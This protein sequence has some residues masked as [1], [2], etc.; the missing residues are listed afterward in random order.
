MK[1]IKL[2][3]VKK[4][5]S[6]PPHQI[7]V[8]KNITQTF[9]QGSS[10]AITGAS[11]SGKSTLLHIIGGLDQPTAGSIHYNDKPIGELY[12][13]ADVA[14][15]LGFVFQLPY[16]IDE[17]TVR[18][19]VLLPSLVA[20]SQPHSQ[21]EALAL[22]RDVGLSEKIDA[23][24]RTLSGGQQQRVAIARALLGKPAFL[25]A[26]EPTGN[27]DATTGSEIIDLLLEYQ[28]KFNMGLIICS[29]DPMIINRLDHV[30][31]LRDGQLIE[32][33]I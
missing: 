23:L 12:D 10:Y 31:S 4:S 18:E 22:L 27:L 7:E 21:D 26:D 33:S 15:H 20:T 28:K 25:L 30:V 6:V 11:G 13:Q 24:P 19:N 5:F 32:G 9:E 2:Q 8:L 3:S 17:L 16:L 1:R 29:H 14:K